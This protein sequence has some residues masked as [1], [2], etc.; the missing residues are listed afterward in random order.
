MLVGSYM[1]TLFHACHKSLRERAAHGLSVLPKCV[2]VGIVVQ[3]HY[4][5]LELVDFKMGNVSLVQPDPDF[6]RIK[7]LVIDSGTTYFT[8]PDAVH[9]LIVDRIQEVTAAQDN[10]AAATGLGA[11][12]WAKRCGE[13]RYDMPMRLI[14]KMLR[15]TQ[16]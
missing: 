5:A 10:Q 6:P 1:R 12:D 8:A 11:W 16:S 3:P 4:W 15:T 9:D 14:A 2:R 7:R 13:S